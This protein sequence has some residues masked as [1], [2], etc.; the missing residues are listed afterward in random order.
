[1]NC[2]CFS[3][4]VSLL[5]CFDV[6]HVASEIAYYTYLHLIK[7]RKTRTFL[8]VFNVLTML[9]I[10]MQQNLILWVTF[11]SYNISKKHLAYY[12]YRQFSFL[13]GG[14]AAQQLLW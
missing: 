9:I 14:A 4:R 13:T 3:S 12:N 2:K 5:C 11:T 8:N 7:P 10:F 1:M 6:F